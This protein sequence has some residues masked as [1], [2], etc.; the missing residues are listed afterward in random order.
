M[1]PSPTSD[2]LLTRLPG[3]AMLALLGL[4]ALG[5]LLGVP[6]WSAPDDAGLLDGDWTDAIESSIDEAAGHRDLSIVTWALV[7]YLLFHD[8][9]DGVLL[10]EDGWLFTSEEFEA[11]GDESEELE[12]KLLLIE[13]V[14]DLLA[15]Q[16]AGLT[17]AVVPSKARIHPERLGSLRFPA[18][19]QQRYDRFRGALEER[20]IAAP[21]LAQA[22]LEA[23]DQGVAVYLRT[24]THWTPAGAAVVARALSDELS[25]EGKGGS[26]YQTTQGEPT[27]H[28]GDLLSYVPLGPFQASL[29]P[30]PDTL[31][32]ATTE[33]AQDPSAGLGL[34]DEVSIPVTLVGTSYS[35]D[36]SWNFAGA[37]QQA[38]GADVLNAA[39]KGRGPLHPMREYLAD[40]AF[41]STPP[42]MVI[43][44]IPERFLAKPYEDEAYAALTAGEQ[45]L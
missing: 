43:W 30:Q 7:E 41:R 39:M 26:S 31:L 14:R 13:S 36:P 28:E 11:Y 44:E 29:G 27:A 37:L 17:V 33:A 3:I 23:K 21:D 45:P 24:D 12:R 19:A 22:L 2:P 9:R 10:G 4:G 5:T 32:P 18:Y 35:A 6:D 8:G 20:G 40:D 42:S 1:S 38:L 16:G 34:F 25:F 15:A